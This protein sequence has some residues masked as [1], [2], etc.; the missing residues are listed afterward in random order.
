MN[1]IKTKQNKVKYKNRVVLK[2]TLFLCSKLGIQI[3]D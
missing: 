1:F 2:A 3:I